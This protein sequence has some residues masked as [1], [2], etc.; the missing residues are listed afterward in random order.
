MSDPDKKW[1]VKWDI[2]KNGH[3]IQQNAIFETPI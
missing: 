2:S 1:N 3:P